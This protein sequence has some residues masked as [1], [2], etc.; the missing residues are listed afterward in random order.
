MKPY[1][2]MNKLVCDSETK[3]ARNDP[4]ATVLLPRRAGRKRRQT[5]VSPSSHVVLHRTP[6]I[7]L[8][9]GRTDPCRL[10][11]ATLGILVTARVARKKI[12]TMERRREASRQA[13]RQAAS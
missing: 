1:A 11:S 10:E 9:A 5:P 13:G 8:N 2:Q 6:H 4:L 3:T 7:L 12:K